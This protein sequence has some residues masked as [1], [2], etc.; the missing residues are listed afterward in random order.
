GAF[1]DPHDDALEQRRGAMD[2]V[3]VTVGDRVEGGR[4]DRD[5]VARH[6][7]VGKAVHDSTGW[8]DAKCNSVITARSRL[9]GGDRARDAPHASAARDAAASRSPG[10]RARQPMT[11]G[12]ATHPRPAT[13]PA[14]RAPATT[15]RHRMAGQG[16]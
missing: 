11:P 6:A 9:R 8:D 16:R 14:H 1:G 10:P 3:D 5:A 2:E 12:T 13:D 4:T 15:V 7:H